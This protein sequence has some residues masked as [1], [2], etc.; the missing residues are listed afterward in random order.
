MERLTALKE[1]IKAVFDANK[2][3]DIALQQAVE[4]AN[5][6]RKETTKALAAEEEKRIKL[7]KVPEKNRQT[8]EELEALEPNLEKERKAAEEKHTKIMESL[9]QDT[10]A[11]Q[12]S[13]LEKL[14]R[15]VV[16]I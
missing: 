12:V 5:K 4:N 1:S 13:C 8:I 16:A 15:S 14:N 6:K 2:L 11:L 9:A 3:N 7:E 10:Q